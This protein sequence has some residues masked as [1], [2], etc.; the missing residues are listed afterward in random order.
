MRQRLKQEAAA[1]IAAS[2]RAS[3]AREAAGLSEHE[4]RTR[5]VEMGTANL[6]RELE[7]RLSSVSAELARIQGDAHAGAHYGA[8]HR[9]RGSG[10]PSEPSVDS[11]VRPA[12][13]ASASPSLPEAITW[14]L[15]KL[16]PQAPST[17]QTSQ[18]LNPQYV[19]RYEPPPPPPTLPPP[20]P[21][22]PLPAASPSIEAIEAAADAQASEFASRLSAVQQSLAS[23]HLARLEATR[24]L[25][26]AQAH[27]LET[28]LELELREIEGAAA[29]ADE[30]YRAISAE[31]VE[32]QS[33]TNLSIYVMAHELNAAEKQLGAI[34]LKLTLAEKRATEAEKRAHAAAAEAAAHARRADGEA[35][36]R[37]RAAAARAEAEASWCVARHA[38]EEALE[39]A[40]STSAG[41]EANWQLSR[42][43]EQARA[44]EAS[45]ALAVSALDCV[46]MTLDCVPHQ[47]STAL[48][49]LGTA[50]ADSER[51][52]ARC[53]ELEGRLSE[54]ASGLATLREQLATSEARCRASEARAAVMVT[55]M[56]L[57][58]RHAEGDFEAARGHAVQ[59]RRAS[60]AEAAE[61]DQYVAE[62]RES[63]DGSS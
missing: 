33:E 24:N 44:S 42:R 49:K 34:R 27:V 45:T 50:L 61:R 54:Q 9:W 1:A 7:E 38:L 12:A 2:A 47:A 19:W 40:R 26:A 48:A 37:E 39:T 5:R 30:A 11:S 41:A 13:A 63:L 35:L 59:L 31:L 25:H 16:S 57:E 6:V 14:L 32:A 21:T 53:A 17:P 29:A 3:A 43:A 55:Q 56:H 52:G 18:P 8:G 4:E 10:A 15:E 62:V 36:E 60:L 22:L 51:A 46:L 23:C 28:T 58:L 20:P